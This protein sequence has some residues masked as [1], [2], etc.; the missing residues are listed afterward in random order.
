[1]I[2]ISS[3]NPDQGPLLVRHQSNRGHSFVVFDMPSFWKVS[4]QVSS[5]L[6]VHVLQFV[7]NLQ[8]NAC[9]SYQDKLETCVKLN[10]RHP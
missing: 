3:T 1:M 2:I 4:F 5:H 6:G 8:V 9:L 10:L 7:I